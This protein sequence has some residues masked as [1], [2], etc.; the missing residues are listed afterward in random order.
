MVRRG[1]ELASSSSENPVPAIPELELENPNLDDVDSELL[2]FDEDLNVW[3]FLAKRN[4][5]ISLKDLSLEEQKLF[6]ESDLLEW[7]AILKTKAVH[8]VVGAEAASLRAKYAD[9]IVS[10]R[11][12]RR[13]KP[14]PD[15]LHGWKA[16]SRWCLHGHRDPDRGSLITYAPTPQAEGMNL[17]M[18]VGL[19][20]GHSFVFGDVKNAFCQ[21]DPL[22]RQGGPL[23]AEPCPGLNLPAGALIVI[24]LPVYGLDDAPAAWRATVAK[25]LVE[26][27]GFTRN[28]IEPCWYVKFD[29]NRRNIAQALV[30]VDDFIISTA[31]EHKEAIKQAFTTR[32]HFGK[33]E[34]D[35][36]EYAGRRIRVLSDR[37]LIDQEKYILEQLQPIALAKGRRTDKASLLQGEEFQAFRS[38]IYR[39]NS[40][41]KETRPEMSGLASIMAS[42][43]TSAC[44]EDALTVNKAVNHLR[45][46]ASRALTLWKYDPHSMVFLAVSDAGGINSKAEEIDELGLPSD[47]TQGAWMVLAAEALPLGIS[48][49]EPLRLPGGAQS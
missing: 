15:K 42:K 26:D 48:A 7:E 20:L 16:K 4:D 28:L 22:R 9:R 13:K 49:S 38:C 30:E 40:V 31:P 23:F 41:A 27:M 6:E 44:V 18:Q 3:S 37:A 25:F 12:V 39:I 46:S 17:F 21:S 35:Q 19:N 11:L 36:A 5:E 1:R 29:K 24:D 47:S 2:T 33:W 8:V 14:V 32:F 34:P 45:N 10:S 43:L